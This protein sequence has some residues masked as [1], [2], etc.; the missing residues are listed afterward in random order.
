MCRSSEQG[1]P[2]DS[3]AAVLRGLCWAAELRYWVH[4]LCHGGHRYRMEHRLSCAR[5]RLAGGQGNHEGLQRHGGSPIPD[6]RRAVDVC[7][8]LH[9]RRSNRDLRKCG[10]ASRTGAISEAS[11]CRPALRIR[12]LPP[13]MLGCAAR[14]PFAES[15]LLGTG[16]ATGTTSSS[17][18]LLRSW[19]CRIPAPASS[20]LVILF[21][22]LS[23]AFRMTAAKPLEVDGPYPSI[24]LRRAGSLCLTLTPSVIR[25]C[26]QCGHSLVLGATAC[27]DATPCIYGADLNVLARDAKAL[28]AG[29]TMRRR[30][31]CG[32][33]HCRCFPPDSKQA[34]W[35]RDHV[36]ALEIAHAELEQAAARPAHPWRADSARSLRSPS[37]WPRSKTLL[38][39]SSS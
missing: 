3:H 20:G 15:N 10:E 38:R 33:A 31:R 11:R 5:G 35:V 13:T 6:R 7:F 16:S 36:R 8:H 39:P 27:P 19:N 29:A 25:E 4:P 21:V 14:E 2:A 23:I 12:P 28:E 22:G 26:P 34:E 32:T 1:Q 17:A 24:R 9:V 18:W 30:A 37:C